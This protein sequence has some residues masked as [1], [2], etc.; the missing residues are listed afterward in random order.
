[1]LTPGVR[2]TVT[3]QVNVNGSVGLAQVVFDVNRE[4]SGGT[5]QVCRIKSDGQGSCR[6]Y[7]FSV[8]LVLLACVMCESQRHLQDVPTHNGLSTGCRPAYFSFCLMLSLGSVACNLF[9]NLPD[10]HVA[11]LGRY[12]H[13]AKSPFTPKGYRIKCE[14]QSL[15]DVDIDIQ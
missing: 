9:E 3:L 14:A 1:M 4:P 10:T 7:V 13:V 15:K 11:T 6:Y 2:Y 8:V 12:A 5:C